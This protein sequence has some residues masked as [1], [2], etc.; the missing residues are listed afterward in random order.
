MS[1]ED[2]EMGHIEAVNMLLNLIDPIYDAHL[3][4]LKDVEMRLNNWDP[5]YIADVL[6][7]HFNNSLQVIFRACYT[8]VLVIILNIYSPIIFRLLSRFQLYNQYLDEHLNVLEK[9]DHTYRTNKKFEAFY[10]DFEMEKVCYLP[11]SSFVLKPLQR[12]LHYSHLLESTR[13]IFICEILVK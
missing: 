6:L 5:P 2:D 4:F 12:L 3:S 9:I 11:L 1:K 10:K 13:R 7:R 8:Y